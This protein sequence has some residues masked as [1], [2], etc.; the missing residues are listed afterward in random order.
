MANYRQHPIFIGPTIGSAAVTGTV[1]L[2][3]AATWMAYSFMGNGKTLN[4]VRA[5]L[6]ATAGTMTAAGL[7][8]ELYSDSASSP[9]AS[10]EGPKN[11][12]TTPSGSGWYD[13]TGFTTVT[14]AGTR[15]WLVFKNAQGTPAS[16]NVTFR[17]VANSSTFSALGSASTFGAAKKHSTDSGSTWAGGTATAAAGWR[18]GFSDGSYLG[19]PLSNFG[20]AGVGV[21]VYST[22]ECGGMFTNPANATL[23]VAGLWILMNVK[24]GTPTGS[25]RLRLYTGSTP[26]LVATTETI[27]ISSVA[28]A[29]LV[30]AYFSSVQQIAPNTI[31]RVVLGETAQADASANRYNVSF[32]TVDTDS[33]SLAL[34]PFGS[35]QQTYFDGTNWA[36][37]NSALVPC[38]LMLDDVAGEFGSGSGGLAKLAGIGGGLIG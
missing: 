20:T 29:S 17:W 21:G 12:S 24:S 6:S 37:T 7:T 36:Q 27:D 15:Y 38:G 14:T 25:G 30:F 5:F 16:N 11:C 26:S 23:N 10:I 31:I 9:N 4:T 8:C 13:W 35:F 1:A 22:R 3:A 33:A 34:M 32:F 28:A 18:I 19:S 2:S